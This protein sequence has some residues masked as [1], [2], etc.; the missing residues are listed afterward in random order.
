M[1]FEMFE[2]NSYEATLSVAVPSAFTTSAV[3]IISFSVVPLTP[4]TRLY[5]ATFDNNGVKTVFF[6]VTAAVVI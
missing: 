3:F 6:V 5:A 2:T 4:V 1:A